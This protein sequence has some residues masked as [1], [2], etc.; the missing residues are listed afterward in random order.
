VITLGDFVAFGGYLAMLVWPTVVMGW[1]LNLLQRGAA[2]MERISLIMETPP[3]IPKPVTPLHRVD[4]TGGITVSHLS[5]R[6]G[7]REILH[8]ISLSIPRGSSLGITGP[9][10]C[11]KSTLAALLARL[12]PQQGGEIRYGDT[13]LS[14]IPEETLR[15]LVAVVPQESIL[16]SR[17]IRE[18]ILYGVERGDEGLLRD[19][20]E[21]ASLAEDVK[22]FEKGYDTLVGERG[23]ML[24]GGQRQRT[25]IARALATGAPVLILDDP[26]SAE[27]VRTEEGI[28]SRLADPTG[29]RIT[30][31]IS[32]RLSP[33]AWCDRI[34]VMNEG[35][36]VEEGDHATLLSRGGAYARLWEMQRIQQELEEI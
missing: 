12:L 13:P 33:L 21:R 28:L 35:R 30:I 15:R 18:N 29:E 26:L 19:V 10:G 5:F 32:H 1:V 23:V 8:D 4:L 16:F 24:S 14:L 9:V 7:E 36:I 31:I 17:S 6:R 34:V 27:D 20:T 3:D 25:A 22:G 2:S 11:G